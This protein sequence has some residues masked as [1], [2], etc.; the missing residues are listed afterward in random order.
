MFKF[1]N[2]A[3]EQLINLLSEENLQS[4]VFFLNEG[5]IINSLLHWLAPRLHIEILPLSNTED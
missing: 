5:E 1:G 4:S 2:W 3:W